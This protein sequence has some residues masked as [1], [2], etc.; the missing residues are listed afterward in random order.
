MFLREK[1]I[2]QIKKSNNIF[3]FKLL[4]KTKDKEREKNNNKLVNAQFSPD[5]IKR[6]QTLKKESYKEILEFYN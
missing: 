1:K 3:Y 2:N 6:M 5:F 4:I